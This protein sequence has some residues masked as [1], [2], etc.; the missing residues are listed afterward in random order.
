MSADHWQNVAQRW[1]LLGSPLRP[2]AAD[3][4]AFER[5]IRNWSE[6]YEK[7]PRGLILGVTPELYR[8]HWPAGS[9][10][11]AVDHTQAMIDALWPGPQGDAHRGEW[12]ELP[13]DDAAFDVVLCDGGFHLLD[14]PHGQRRLVQQVARVLCDG[15]LFVLRL[16]VPPTVRESPEQVL[17]A[18]ASGGIPNLNVLKLRLGMALQADEQGGVALHGVWHTLCTAQPDFPALA[19]RLGWELPHLQAIDSYRNS[20][21]HYHFVSTARACQLFCQDP[22]GFALVT[23]Q[24]CTYELGERCPIVVL[25][26]QPREAA[27]EPDKP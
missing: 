27:G 17:Q 7:P 11:S 1:Q 23:T 4:A 10:V 2:I 19:A 26:R 14:H 9:R 20:P 15:G 24:T 25:R 12:T 3:V 6:H 18:L 8:L 22:G 21:N 5:A 16:F 13:F